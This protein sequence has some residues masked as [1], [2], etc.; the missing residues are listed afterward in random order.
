MVI[1]FAWVDRAFQ[2]GAYEF[3]SITAICIAYIIRAGCGTGA[4]MIRR[5]K[6]KLL[7][8]WRE[9]HIIWQTNTFHWGCSGERRKRSTSN[10]YQRFQGETGI[11]RRAHIV[12]VSPC[13]DE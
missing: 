10:C 3:L 13:N 11:S 6:R 4:Q 12:A 5:R 9:T 1:L 2:R 8:I 7:A